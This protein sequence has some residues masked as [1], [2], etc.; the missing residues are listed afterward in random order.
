M[1]GEVLKIGLGTGLNLPYYPD[2]IQKLTTIDVN[3]GMS[4]IAQKRIQAIAIAVIKVWV[5]K[6]TGDCHN[7]LNL[8]ITSSST[9]LDSLIIKFSRD[10]FE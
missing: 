4:G 8:M 10:L 7:A 9:H 5:G 2:R 3:P 6:L 1:Q